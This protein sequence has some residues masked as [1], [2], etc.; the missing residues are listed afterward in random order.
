MNTFP[1][2]AIHQIE[3]TSRCNLRCKYCPSPH[4]ARPKVDMTEAIFMRSLMWARYF[5]QLNGY[6]EL[7]LA[8]IG[9]STLHPNFADWVLRAREAMGPRVNLVLATNGLLMND[10]L[11]QAIAPAQPSVFVSLHRP[12]RA[13]PAVE[14]LRRA[15][16]FAGHSNDPSIAATDWAGQVN[17]HRSAGPHR[18]CPWVRSAKVMV[19]ADGRVTRCS[20][21][22]SG[23]GVICHIDEDLSKHATSPYKLCVTCDQ[24]VGVPMTEEAVA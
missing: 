6:M 9:E 1:I 24:D 10:E 3:M 17:W 16:I 4:L 11:A 2:R 21:D 19:M 12:E 7:N 23:I 8:G 14:A 22:A 15:G 18:Q 20:L 5:S 13:G